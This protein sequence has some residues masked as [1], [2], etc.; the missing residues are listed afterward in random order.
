MSPP[1]ASPIFHNVHF[2]E[3]ADAGRVDE[4]TE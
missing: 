4:V 2:G 1:S 3:I